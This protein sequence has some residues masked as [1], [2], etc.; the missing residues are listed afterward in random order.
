M[1]K[2]QE[3]SRVLSLGWEDPLEEG[4][5]PTSVFLPGKSQGQRSLAGYSPWGCKE[6]DMTTIIISPDILTS[7]RTIVP[8]LNVQARRGTAHCEV[9]GGTLQP[10]LMCEFFDLFSC[11]G[12][13]VSHLVSLNFKFLLCRRMLLGE[14]KK[15]L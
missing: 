3:T 13:S 9:R 5:Q 11:V 6:S 12:P 14:L 10:H 2:T 15:Y 8:V 7:L 4:M 1:L